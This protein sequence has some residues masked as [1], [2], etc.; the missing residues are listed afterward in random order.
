MCTCCGYKT[1][2]DDEG[3]YDICPIC[4]WE[5][6]PYQNAHVYE[7]GGANTVS[8]IEAQKNYMDFGACERRV[9]PY[10]REPYNHDKKDPAWRVAKDNLSHVREIC[11]DFEES[12]IS[13]N[14]L[15]IRLSECKVPDHMEKS[16]DKARQ[17]IEKINFYTS[18]YKQ[19]EEVIPVLHHMLSELYGYIKTK[20]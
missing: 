3:S 13:I 11:N 10:T 6:D 9:I 18:V 19:R 17:E 12:N 8:L 2:E 5:D 4:F 15:D 1:L 7:A 20:G 16:V 14:E